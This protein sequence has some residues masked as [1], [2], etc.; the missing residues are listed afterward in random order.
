MKIKI[1]YLIIIAL[2]LVGCS[3]PD[4]FKKGGVD[5]TNLEIE[6]VEPLPGAAEIH[7]LIKGKANKVLKCGVC[8]KE[9]SGYASTTP[10][11]EADEVVYATLTE[12]DGFSVRVIFPVKGYGYDDKKYTVRAF[13]T[14]EKG[15]TIYS[16]DNLVTPLEPIEISGDKAHLVTVNDAVIGNSSGLSV[17]LSAGIMVSEAIEVIEQGFCWFVP[18][19]SDYTPS[20][21]N[22]K[23]VATSSPASTTMTATLN[24]TEK[25]T[26]F[27]RAY[28][29]TQ[30]GVK[31]SLNTTKYEVEETTVLPQLSPVMVVSEITAKSAIFTSSVNM[32][33]SY[34]VTKR[35]FC[36]IADFM[37][38]PDIG[39]NAIECPVNSTSE[40]SIQANNLQ[41]DSFHRVR[42]FATNSSG[43]VYSEINEFIT[44]KYNPLPMLEHSPVQTSST[45]NSVTVST[46]VRPGD[47]GD[48]I[49][50]RGFCWSL[51][52]REPTTKDNTLTCGS[53]EGEYSGTI[54]GLKPGG[55]IYVRS[56]ATNRLGV[57]YSASYLYTCA[58]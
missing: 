2:S 37:G 1:S 45:P 12:N 43:T 41:A 16:Q 52:S 26:H 3:Y 33:P 46:K 49:T 34:G 28:I 9:K 39:D 53:G 30:H 6:S 56:Y 51:T 17:P 58:Y 54:E 29:W 4:S 40:F 50:E 36:W 18:V 38:T 55:W 11:I 48:Q 5:I 25:G 15:V 22:H 8:W 32:T 44:P 19:Y 10:T 42:A 14:L 23:V 27:I 57:V 35:G 24:L 7:C 47:S 31:Y 13:V 21:K 20:V